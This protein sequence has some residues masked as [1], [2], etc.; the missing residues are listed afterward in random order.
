MGIPE[1]SLRG[2]FLLRMSVCFGLDILVWRFCF[3][4]RLIGACGV[5]FVMLAF[6][7]WLVPGVCVT[8]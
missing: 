4:V 3:Y 6:A 2:L 7:V 8:P 1:F 5:V